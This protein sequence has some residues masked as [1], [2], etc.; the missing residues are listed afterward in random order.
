M[1][2]LAG[3]QALIDFGAPVD[4]RAVDRTASAGP[5]QHDV[6]GMDGRNRHFRDLVL[7]NEF[8]RGLRLERGEIAGHGA[9]AAAHVLI[10]EAA[11]QEK[12]Q[13]HDRRVEIGV[14]GVID[15]LDQGRAERQDDA[16]RDRHV[17]VDASGAQR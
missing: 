15:G 17:H 4:D 13:E 6:A 12:G 14:L 1:G 10:E 2:R 3:D 7:A 16:D 5:E 9:G 11:D 8:R